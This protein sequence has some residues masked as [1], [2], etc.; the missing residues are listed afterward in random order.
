M[1]HRLVILINNFLADLLGRKTPPEQT[2]LI[3]PHCLQNR[4]CKFD[5]C[6]DIGQCR[7]C[8]KCAMAD[9]IDLKA[10]FGVQVA[11]ANGGRQAGALV[12]DRNVRSVIA[13]ACEKELCAGILTIPTKRIYAIPNHRPCGPCVDTHVATDEI[14]KVLERTVRHVK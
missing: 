12:R 3:V 7:R 6:A 11:V 10:E 2:L 9:L 13:V 1:L 5:V 8:R 14:R 4:A